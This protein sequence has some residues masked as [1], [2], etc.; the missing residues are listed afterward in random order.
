MERLARGSLAHLLE[1]RATLSAGEAVT[2]LTPMAAAL[3]ALHASGVVH[4]AIGAQSVMFRESGAPV[5]ARFGRSSLIAP[6]QSDAALAVNEGVVADRAALAELCRIVLSRTGVTRA[7]P[8]ASSD[9]FGEALADELFAVAPPTVVRFT[10]DA[11]PVASAVPARVGVRAAFAPQAER[12]EGVLARARPIADAVMAQARTVRRPVWLAAA[13]VIVAIIAAV[14]LIPADDPVVKAE[15][16]STVTV[17][18]E[19]EIVDDP[20]AALGALL[21]AREQCIAAV[22]VLCLDAVDQQG[23]QAFDADAGLLAGVQNGEEIPDDTVISASDLALVERLGDTALVS[24]GPDS[25]PASVLLVKTEAGWRIRD[26][27][28]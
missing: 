5:L 12:S 22:S 18:A 8:P 28:D 20:L 25:K 24:L 1:M 13:S 11:T 10:G 17:E 16:Q 27:L 4:G 23:S 26:Y 2:I 19:E 14:L 6:G 7:L 15:P 3:D 21:S 9:A